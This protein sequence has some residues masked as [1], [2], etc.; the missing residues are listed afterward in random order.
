[1]GEVVGSRQLKAG[2]A[3][4]KKSK[5]PKLIKP[6]RSGKSLILHQGLQRIAGLPFIAATN[7]AFQKKSF[8]YKIAS[9]NKIFASELFAFL[10]S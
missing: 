10:S 1:M 6:D 2:Y 9:Q 8:K 7:P 4:I 3:A 5:K